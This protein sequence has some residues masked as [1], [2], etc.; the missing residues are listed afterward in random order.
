MDAPNS[1]GE[2]AMSGISRSGA[3]VAFF[4]VASLPAQA[5]GQISSADDK[6]L[7]DYVLTM[8]KVKAYEAAT[9]NL[10]AAMKADPAVKAEEEKASDEPDKTLADV[11]AKF[12]R[13]PRFY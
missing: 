2:I 5:A 8:A 1:K 6:A 9:K 3:A 7:H 13:H 4:L 11:K 12:T 10:G